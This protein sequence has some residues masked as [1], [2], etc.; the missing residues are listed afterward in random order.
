M[1]HFQF[2]I[3]YI[4]FILSVKTKYSVHSPFVY[5]LLTKVLNKK[6][7]NKQFKLIENIRKELIHN[8]ELITVTDLGAGSSIQNTRKRKI[9]YI[10]K[11]SSSSIKYCKLI[12][13][14][15]QHFESKNIIE[16]G[17]SFGICTM[18]QAL[19]TEGAIYTIEGC[20]IITEIAIKN[21]KKA[22]MKN[23]NLINGNFD[24]ELRVL[25]EKIN[26]PDLIFI[27]GNHRKEPTIKYFEQCIPYTHDKTIL[28]FDDIHWSEGMEEAWEYIKN[29]DKVS[30]SLD[31]FF[32]GIAFISKDFS[33]QNFCLKV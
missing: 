10:A 12:Y 23:I 17:S 22:G 9:S 25:L 2:I 7:E 6:N 26:K 31:L 3:R 18:Y 1:N 4:K 8:N 16:L 21:F 13:N 33:K 27:D 32:M 30:L 11:T 14:L 5:D 15:I 24:Y 19:A 28:I 20:P 29:H